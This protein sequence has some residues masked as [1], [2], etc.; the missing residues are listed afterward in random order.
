M[1]FID[2]NAVVNH[3]LFIRR[4]QPLLVQTFLQRF[5]VAKYLYKR[6]KRRRKEKVEVEKNEEKQI[7]KF[8]GVYLLVG[9][10]LRL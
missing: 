5:F 9:P 6:R 1:F 7:S 3:A 8:E 10:Y 4:F 2:F